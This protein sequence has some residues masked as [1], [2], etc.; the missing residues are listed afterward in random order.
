MRSP[1][2]ADDG[3]LEAAARWVIELLSGQLV[4][5]IAV[6]AV[7]FLGYEMLSGRISFRRALR[8][9]LG[10]FILLG[11]ATIAQEI[12]GA[13]RGTI[14]ETVR[15]VPSLS[16]PAPA[17]AYPPANPPTR[18]SG[19]PFDPYSSNPPPNREVR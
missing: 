11:S 3:S 8:V 6:I 15:V 12:V 16:A 5:A 2:S 13:G 7:A 4:M 19:N 1:F 18:T 9:V 14:G 10:C 17:P